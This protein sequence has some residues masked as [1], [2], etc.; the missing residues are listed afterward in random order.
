MAIEFIGDCGRGKST[1][2]R[3]LQSRLPQSTY[4]YL[5]EDAPVPAIPDRR[6]TDH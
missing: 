1:R 4:V 3:W 5:P 2:L 6:S